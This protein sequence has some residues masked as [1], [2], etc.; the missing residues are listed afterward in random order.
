MKYRRPY[1]IPAS[2]L[3][4]MEIL[5]PW[6]KMRSDPTSVGLKFINASHGLESQTLRETI[7]EARMNYY[8]PTA[9]PLEP[10]TLFKT[11]HDTQN[12]PLGA[13]IEATGDGSVVVIEA[14]DL[15]TFFN[16]PPTRLVYSQSIGPLLSGND[17]A[18]LTY[19]MGFDASGSWVL[20]DAGNHGVYVLSKDISTDDYTTPQV[21]VV[22]DDTV[23]V[24]TPI[25]TYN[26]GRK[27]QSFGVTGKDEQIHFKDGE[28]LLAHTPISSSLRVLDILNLDPTGN[29]T[30]VDPTGYTLTDNII[31]QVLYD[32]Y[33]NDTPWRSSYIAEYDYKVGEKVN[34]LETTRD[35][36][37]TSRWNQD[38]AV[39][40][41]ASSDD[42]GIPTPFE[43]AI[44]GSATYDLVLRVDPEIMIPGSTGVV[45]VEYPIWSSGQAWTSNYMDMHDIDADFVSMNADMVTHVYGGAAELLTEDTHY[46]KKILGENGH[47]VAIEGTGTI[48]TFDVVYTKKVQIE[49][50]A[51]QSLS[52]TAANADLYPMDYTIRDGKAYPYSIIQIDADAGGLDAEAQTIIRTGGM[53]NISLYYRP[54]YKGVAY[55]PLDD[56]VWFFDNNGLQ[57]HIFNSSPLR[58][59]GRKTLQSSVATRLYLEPTGSVDQLYPFVNYQKGS[60]PLSNASS[61]TIYKDWLYVVGNGNNLLRYSVFGDE[62]VI[63]AETTY[64]LLDT[65]GDMS[66][67]ISGHFLFASGDTIALYRPYYDY[68]M[69]DR[70][71]GDVYFR[72]EYSYVEVG[73]VNDG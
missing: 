3:K 32:P 18:G 50:T 61:C 2:S 25:M 14:D 40:F 27:T 39:G 20:G 46:T 21:V 30:L 22:P 64:S 72:E 55:Q 17:I 49:V 68:F 23:G 9:D 41:V 54:D 62:D 8:L 1:H 69:V 53:H 28:V 19:A 43:Q 65:H 12:G 34:R 6:M 58:M 59:K 45:V 63:S 52:M 10:H 7:E 66:V 37:G 33:V 60:D 24:I 31:Q 47:I 56:E 48:G 71:R 73:G 13:T 29:A 38:L 11:T 4:S 16:A 67:S 51:Q 42:M 5:P 35:F 44:G 15:Y 26:I 57:V 36:W 70:D